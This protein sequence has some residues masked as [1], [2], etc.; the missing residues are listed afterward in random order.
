M[1]LQQWHEFLQ[2]FGTQHSFNDISTPVMNETIICDL[3]HLGLLQI[4]G[5]DAVTFMQGQVTND[6]KQLNGSNAH[7]TGY[8]TP[9]GRLLALFL[10]FAH[11]GHIHL[12]LPKPLVEPI[13]KRLKMYVLRSKVD[14]Q[15]ASES[16]IKIGLNG[17]QAPELLSALFSQVPQNDFE[18]V[19]LDNGALL[20]LPGSQPRFEIFTD[21]NQAPA[22]WNALLKHAKP[23]SMNVWEWLEVQAGIPD[24]VISTQEEFV[25]QMLNLDLIG[26]IN[27]KK[28]CYTGQE[29]VAR[30]HYLGTVKRRTQLAHVDSANPPVAGDNVTNKSNDVI[31]KVVRS[32]KAPNGGYDILAEI[33]LESVEAEEVYVNNAKLEVKALPYPL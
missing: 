28:G 13:T 19:T 14:I 8:C 17:S 18:L 23:V 4:Q 30:T 33:R 9:K 1:S 11:H 26:G 12:Q 15:D 22:I 29:I 6:V 3:S 27:F 7:Y 31:G 32:A 21:L 5:A 16:I 10:A 24:V 25:P 20:K 2:N